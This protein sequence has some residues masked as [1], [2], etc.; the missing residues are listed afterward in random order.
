[1]KRITIADTIR[2]AEK[3]ARE[4]LANIETYPENQRGAMRTA[5]ATYKRVAA[6]LREEHGSGSETTAKERAAL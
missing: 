4:I 1:M 5:A 6:Q 3:A 2:E